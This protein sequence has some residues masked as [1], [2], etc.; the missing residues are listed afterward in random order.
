MN[1]AQSWYGC[2]TA[3]RRALAARDTAKSTPQVRSFQQDLRSVFVFFNNSAVRSNKLLEYHKHLVVKFTQPHQVR[4]LSIHKA[5]SPER[6]PEAHG[7]L[8]RLGCR[9]RQRPP[10]SRQAVHLRRP[11]SHDEGCTCICG[12]SLHTFTKRSEKNS[13]ASLYT[14]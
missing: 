14:N 11:L 9:Q 12:F 10:A 5:G 6:C 8:P 4:W 1:S 3:H 13:S 2:T 7:C